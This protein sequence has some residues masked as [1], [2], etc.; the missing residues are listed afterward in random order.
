[1]Q[2]RISLRTAVLLLI[3]VGLC[4]YFVGSHTG[5]VGQPAVATAQTPIK[6]KVQSAWP[7]TSIV[8][9]AAKLLVDTINK[10]SGGRLQM[11]LSPAGAIVPPFDVEVRYVEEVD[12][13]RF[14]NYVA[15]IGITFALTLTA[16]PVLAVPAGFTASGLP[17]G[18][19]IMAPPRADG[20]ALAAGAL[21]EEATGIARRLPIDPLSPD[22]TPLPLA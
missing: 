4:A 10:T 17:V 12:G 19:Q 22:G 6:W 18:L 13:V 20:A 2:R 5:S 16:C 15:W 9:D 8:Q 1:M 3:V 7:P 14:D 21:L 11:E